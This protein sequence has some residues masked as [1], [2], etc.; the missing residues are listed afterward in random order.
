[1]L[2]HHYSITLHVD[3]CCAH[4]VFVS[5]LPHW[6]VTVVYTLSNILSFLSFP[7]SFLDWASP[8]SATYLVIANPIHTHIQT[9]EL[10][11]DSSNIRYQGVVKFH[12]G[13]TSGSS[14]L[15]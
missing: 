13:A 10:W 11:C 14:V 7:L 6:Q 5:Y 15:R 4:Q 3:I 8:V 2:L 12:I 9:F 1:M